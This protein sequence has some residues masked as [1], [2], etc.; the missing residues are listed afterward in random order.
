[1][2]I[3]LTYKYKFGYVK[4]ALILDK[5]EVKLKGS[6][7]VHYIDLSAT[8]IQV[9]NLA[10]SRVL[11]LNTLLNIFLYLVVFPQRPS[12]LLLIFA[13]R[14]EPSMKLKSF[15]LDLSDETIF[16]DDKNNDSKLPQGP[17]IRIFIG[18]LRSIT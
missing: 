8:Q 18:K 12:I 3:H 1:M 17:T 2:K 4:S 13:L 6:L 15:Q 16:L 5:C 10:I 14:I 11:Y 9:R 7:H